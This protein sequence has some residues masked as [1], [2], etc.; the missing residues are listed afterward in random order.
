[1][2]LHVGEIEA[3][4]QLLPTSRKNLTHYLE[5]CLEVFSG[6]RKKA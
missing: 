1:M 3:F 5:F 6:R 2:R 4:K